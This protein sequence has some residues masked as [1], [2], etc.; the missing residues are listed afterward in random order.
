[1]YPRLIVSIAL[2]VELLPIAGRAQTIDSQLSDHSWSA[3]AYISTGV[4]VENGAVQIRS[5][6]GGAGASGLV[7]KCRLNA[8]LDVQVDYRILE[9]PPANQHSVGLVADDIPSSVP[10]GL[11]S[12]GGAGIFRSNA[13]TTR[14]EL[15]LLVT[16]SGTSQHATTES[17]GTLRLVRRGN[18]VSG[19]HG[20]PPGLT[21]LGSGAASAAPTRVSIRVTR[22]MP[23]TT[24]VTVRFENFKLNAG[25]V[26]CPVDEVKD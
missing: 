4:A 18:T 9:W 16:G 12:S 8:D 5:E 21:L 2:G 20:M 6:P 1:M 24:G 10:G 3:F 26:S 19:Y 23:V 13:A 17:A 14:Q 11:F 22:Q 25:R 15:Y 7:T